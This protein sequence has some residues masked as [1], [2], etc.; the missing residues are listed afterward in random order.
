MCKCMITYLVGTVYAVKIGGYAVAQ[1]SS[2]QRDTLESIINYH[3]GIHFFRPLSSYI[4]LL[5][6]ILADF[7][8][9]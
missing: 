9:T 3:D 6:F 7:L 2:E 1:I 8:A 5:L 4:T